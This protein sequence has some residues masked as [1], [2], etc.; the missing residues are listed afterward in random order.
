MSDA[1]SWLG[2][3]PYVMGGTTLGPAGAD[4]SGF[5]QQIYGRH[6]ISAPR[7]SEAQGGWVKRSGPVPGGLAFYVS[8]G[9]G[10]PPGHVAIVQDASQV[11]SQG[12]GMGPKM[13]A[14]H[15]MPL[16]WTGIPP[17]GFPAGAVGGGGSPGSSSAGVQQWAG[18]ISQALAMVGLS[19]GL[20]GKVEAQ[21][22][23]ESGGNK[24]AINLT[25][26]NAQAGHPSKGLMQVIDGTFAL[27]HVAGTS[28]NIYD[29]LA[30]IAAGLNYAKNRYGSNLN[31]LGQ[32]HG[33]ANGGVIMEPV[34]GVG[35]RS[36]AGYMFGEKGPETVT[37]GLG[38]P[39]G[40]GPTLHLLGRIADALDRLPA[41]TGGAVGDVL[42]GTAATAAA[43]GWYG[44]T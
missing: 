14:L 37:P 5:V 20:L 1:R 4:C 15:G 13:M 42:N 39:G 2:K 23:T 26:S 31:G 33:Y 35:L 40:H 38:G 17:G 18:L 28:N 24:A 36:G 22:Q 16:M 11:I 9:G 34:A 19:P 27:Y 6:G 10:P 8:P 32:G 21:M 43:R 12:G 41:R 25:D 3:I 7:T 44:A 29:P 30:N